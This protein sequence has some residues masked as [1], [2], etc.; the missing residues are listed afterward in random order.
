MIL[1]A[2]VKGDWTRELN[3]YAH[4]E[5]DFP[6]SASEKR[7]SDQRVDV[8]VHVMIDGPY[9]GSSVDLGQYEI[10]LLVAGGSGATFTPGLLDDIVYRCVKAGRPDGERTTRTEF[11]W[12]IKS[13]GHIAWFAQMLADIANLALGSSLEIR[14]SI[15][16][17]CLCGPEAVQFIPNCVVKL[18]RPSVYML[19]CE[20][21]GLSQTH[22]SSDVEEN[23]LIRRSHSGGGVAVCTSGPESLTIE[24]GDA[25]ARLGVVNALKS[26]GVVVH[27]ES[28]AL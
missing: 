14:I 26:G 3:A 17:T 12:C 16:V 19:L 10:V 22:S 15:F 25:V 23:S 24:T 4:N 28:F 6:I 5:Q 27:V 1:A 13:L 20:T 18:E 2:R 8:P 7:D 21:T 11:A 9:G